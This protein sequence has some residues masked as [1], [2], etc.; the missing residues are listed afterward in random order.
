[1]NPQEKGA[2]STAL[3]DGLSRIMVLPQIFALV[4]YTAGRSPFKS[5]GAIAP[6]HAGDQLYEG[7]GAS[8]KMVKCVINSPVEV[9]FPVFREH[10]LRNQQRYAEP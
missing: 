7:L 1:M 4:S 3:L 10:T 8:C 2:F 6:W 9:Q 5:A